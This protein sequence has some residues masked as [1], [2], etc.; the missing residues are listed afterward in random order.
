MIPRF[1]LKIKVAGASEL[2]YQPTTPRSGMSQKIII[3]IH[4]AVKISNLT[5]HK[6]LG[7]FTKL[8]ESTIIFGMSVHLSAW[9]N[10]APTGQI[11]MKF[12]I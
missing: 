9:N 8:Q 4:N 2:W 11:F 10:S 5:F 12:D 7:M 3:L 1:T 6:F